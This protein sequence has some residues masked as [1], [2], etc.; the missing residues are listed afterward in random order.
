MKAIMLC[1]GEGTRCYPFTYLSPKMTQQ[2]CGIPIIEYML[3][4]FVGAPEIDKLYVV[5]K[6]DHVVSVL[7]DYIQK[8]VSYIENISAL[9]SKLGYQVEYRNPNL[10]IEV[11]RANGWGTGGDLRSSIRQI[12]TTDGLDEDFLVCNGDYI[13][14]RK[15]SNNNLTTQLNLSDMIAQHRKASAAM[16]IDMTDALFSVNRSDATRFGV[17][18]VQKI[19]GF[20]VIRGFREKPNI[21]D[22][23]DK[24]WINA[25]V[26]IINTEFAL[27]N[28][29]KILPDKPNTNL[30]K[31]LLEPLA[32]SDDPKMGAY[33]LDLYAWFDV[34]TL[35]QLVDTNIFVGSKKGGYLQA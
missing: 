4:W 34:G 20:D 10:A 8:R 25:G 26:Y 9:F 17:A 13:T 2:V 15:L 23:P 29:D 19:G 22:I 3:S 7:K 11:F 35:Q 14:V 6:S 33:L 5:V 21:D 28:I 27:T 32:R 31:T 30:E 1:A 16:N 24:P 18:D 12:E